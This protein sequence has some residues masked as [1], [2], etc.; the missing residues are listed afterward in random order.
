MSQVLIPPACESL[1]TAQLA[2]SAP[3][4]QGSP[5][6]PRRGGENEVTDCTCPA[7]PSS[8]PRSLV[9]LQRLVAAAVVALVAPQNSFEIVSERA[10][11]DVPC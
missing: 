4:P 7:R 1:P 2:S 10:R 6:T 9:G 3:A 11:L 5:K 8:P